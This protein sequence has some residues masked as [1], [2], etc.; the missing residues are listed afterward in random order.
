M[1]FPSS[2]SRILLRINRTIRA[3]KPYFIALEKYYLEELDVERVVG[4]V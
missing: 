3:W 1:Y 4:H 2:F